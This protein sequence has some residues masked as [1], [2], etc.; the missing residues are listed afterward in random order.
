VDVLGPAHQPVEDDVLVLDR[1]A[2]ETVGHG[3]TG[4]LGR[5][6]TLPASLGEGPARAR[7]FERRLTVLTVMQRLDN[8]LASE[9]RRS[10]F[11]PWR[12]VPAAAGPSDGR[13]WDDTTLLGMTFVERPG[14]R[15][16]PGT[17]FVLQRRTD[18]P[19]VHSA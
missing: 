17:P 6:A 11:R 3:A 2:G 15:R 12:R 8:E 14:L 1:V 18:H 10:P 5:S 13:T 4:V 19:P 16:L 7:D 9:H